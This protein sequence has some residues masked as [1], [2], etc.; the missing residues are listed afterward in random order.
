MIITIGR[1][2]GCS[3]DEVGRKLS[4]LLNIPFY[5][6]KDLIGL[7]REKKI[8]EKYPFYFGEEPVNAMVSFSLAAMISSLSVCSV[9]MQT[10]YKSM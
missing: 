9:Q 6:K 10:P 8:Y 5:T 1:Q 3:G 7:A 2:C 4:K